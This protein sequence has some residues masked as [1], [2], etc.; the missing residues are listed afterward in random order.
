MRVLGLIVAKDGLVRLDRNRCR[1]IECVTIPYT[2]D[3]QSITHCWPVSSCTVV[4]TKKA[5]LLTPILE[6]GGGGRRL[7]K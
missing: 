3:S 7:A 4:Y 5:K 1:K 2:N 6:F